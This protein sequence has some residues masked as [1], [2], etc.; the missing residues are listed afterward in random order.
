LVSRIFTKER[1]EGKI[2]GDIR[3]KREGRGSFPCQ[4]IFLG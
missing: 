4:E 2:E 3:E 1:G